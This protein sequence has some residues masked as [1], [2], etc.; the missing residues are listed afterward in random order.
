MVHALWQRRSVV[1]SIFSKW[2]GGKGV[3]FNL[4][5]CGS[6]TLLCSESLEASQDGAAKSNEET[7]TAGGSHGAVVDHEEDPHEATGGNLE[8]V[9]GVTLNESGPSFIIEAGSWDV[10]T[11]VTE[12][13]AESEDGAG[14]EPAE[15]TAGG[16]GAQKSA[17]A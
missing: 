3:K 2:G 8:K 6:T 14:N 10:A 15:G 5:C 9:V 12:V 7:A 17:E 11:G 16:G 4:C 1:R 13:L